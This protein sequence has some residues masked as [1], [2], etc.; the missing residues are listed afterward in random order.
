MPKQGSLAGSALRVPFDRLHRFTLGAFRAAGLDETDARTGADVLVTTDAWGVFT[1]GT[2]ALNGYLKRLQAGGLNPRG[3]PRVVAEGTAW[4]TIDGDSSLGMVT[5]VFA[6]R[7]AIDRAR[8]HGIAYVGV[9]NSCHFG[10]AGY[11]SSLAADAGML[12]LSMANDLPSVA[13]PGSRGAVTGSNPLSYAIP[14]GRHRSIMLD[15]STA[16]VAG[17]KVYAAKQRGE[18][19]PVGWLVG[20]DGLPTT[21]PGLYPHAAS[22][23]P[24][25]GH[26]GYGLALLIESLSGLLTGAAVT[27]GVGSWMASDPSQPTHHGA[28][29][30]AIDVD[31][32]V[33]AQGL[34][35]RVELLVDEIH[36]APRAD[37]VE[38]I[39]VPGEIEWERFERA[40]KEGI[41]LPKDVVDSLRMASELLGLDLDQEIA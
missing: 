6:M 36:D 9:R 4:A 28:A 5:S 24:A 21:D 8:K 30:L 2:K 39:Y 1:H 37:G 13:A 14:A 38:R 10:A 31:A 27:R 34:G 17:G 19:I 25:A 33:P 35:R 18:P 12:G 23:T 40:M 26:K 3:R 15:M 11:Y 16:T 22:L 41:E 20:P 32:M 29:F 7:D